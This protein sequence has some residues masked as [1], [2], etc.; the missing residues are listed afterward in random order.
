M[1]GTYL[2][3]AL[4]ADG[5]GGEIGECFHHP[6]ILAV[7][8]FGS[9]MGHD[10]DSSLGFAIVPWQKEAVGDGGSFDAEDFEE[11]GQH[12]N[13]LGGSSFEADAA[14]AGVF[15][16]HGIGKTAVDASARNP[17]IEL[18]LGTIVADEGDGGTIGAGEFD[19]DIDQLLQEGCR[20][21][22]KGFG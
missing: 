8:G 17:A 18:V 15:G 7:E 5:Q 11:L 22:D 13:A 3:D 14:G 6:T 9:S 16:K 12:A 2:L 4:L 10:E 20:A 19:G 21:L 1:F